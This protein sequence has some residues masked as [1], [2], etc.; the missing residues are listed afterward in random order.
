MLEE[1]LTNNF[2]LPIAGGYINKFKFILFPLF[3]LIYAHIKKNRL[4]FFLEDT[5]KLVIFLTFTI[6]LLFH[7]IMTKNQI[8]IYFLIP[9][10]FAFLDKEIISS[11][12]K[13]KKYVHVIHFVK[14]QKLLRKLSL[15]AAKF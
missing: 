13:Y 9:L 5:I 12:L 8:Y 1:Q 11:N 6:I 10:L 15:M 7:Q 2:L 3:V 14:I 4:N